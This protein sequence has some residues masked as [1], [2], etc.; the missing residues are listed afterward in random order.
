KFIPGA[1]LLL[2]F[3]S[4]TSTFKLD[5]PEIVIWLAAAY[6]VG[7][8]WDQLMRWFTS[9]LRRNPCMLKCSLENHKKYIEK[10]TGETESAGHAEDDIQKDPEAIKYEYDDAY[11]LLMRHNMLGTVP[12]QEGH[13]NFLRNI[14]VIIVGFFVKVVLCCRGDCNNCNIC[15]L[16]TNDTI[17]MIS[18]VALI[19]IVPIVWFKIQMS[20][21]FTVW[22][23]AYWTQY[24][25]SRKKRINNNTDIK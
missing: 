16:P 7:I 15:D 20:I 10:L 1:L 14:W 21:Y 18:L 6:L 23:N 8:I 3:N 4:N 11:I 25:I 22:D 19:I 17:L 2:L 13:E 5:F 9:C 24:Q 12:K